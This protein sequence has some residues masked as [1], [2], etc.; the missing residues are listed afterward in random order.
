[1]K[2]LYVQALAQNTAENGGVTVERIIYTKRQ[3]NKQ[4]GEGA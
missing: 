4:Q 3:K 2:S 1:M